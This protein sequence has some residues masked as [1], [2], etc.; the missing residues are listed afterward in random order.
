MEKNRLVK[1]LFFEKPTFREVSR[2]S[3]ALE[4][5]GV[6][7]ILMPPEDRGINAH[8]VVETADLPKAREIVR[9]MGL[10]V[11]EKE[12]LL[13]TLDNVPGTLAAA[14]RKISENGINLTYAFSVTMTPALSY[15]LF[16]SADN[17]AALKALS[18]G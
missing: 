2:I 1:E 14:T 9:K 3:K 7:A 6:R 17:R 4:E 16:G 13:I 8:L 11:M 5:H 10:P 18:K 12:V 15:V